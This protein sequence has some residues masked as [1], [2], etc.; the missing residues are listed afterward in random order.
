MQM[1]E[2]KDVH[3]INIRSRG[4]THF[5]SGLTK[6][7]KFV[8]IDKVL[9]IVQPGRQ[10]AKLLFFLQICIEGRSLQF[11]VHNLLLLLLLLLLKCSVK[12]R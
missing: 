2:R 9:S 7:D 8:F 4:A 10:A 11:Q 1:D 6:Q 5:R 3:Y 12:L